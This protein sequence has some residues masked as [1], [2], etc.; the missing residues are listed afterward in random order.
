MQFTNQEKTNSVHIIGSVEKEPTFSH[1]MEGEDFYEMSVAVARQSGQTDKVNV[2]LP[3]VTMSG[4]KLEE[5]D[6]VEIFGD[7]R[8][9]NEFN[10]SEKRN[11]LILY[12]FCKDI[13][14]T[15]QEVD[16]NEI[17]FVGYVCKKPIYRLTPKNREI[18][19]VMIAVNRPAHFERIKSDYIPAIAWGRN[20]KYASSF[21]VGTKI[22]A[23][24][25]IQSRV[26][27]K[28]DENGIKAERTAY[29]VSIYRIVNLSKA[30]DGKLTFEENHLPPAN[31][32]KNDLAL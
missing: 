26:Y 12:L 9:R 15:E 19:D 11:K 18:C 21:E 4:V 28:Q 14:N 2:T 3:Y 25:R 31:L 17:N 29:E 6:R 20:A 7:F 1:K 5:G 30:A 22:E 23:S 8:S 32:D 13:R 10:E 16:I 27:E 24:G